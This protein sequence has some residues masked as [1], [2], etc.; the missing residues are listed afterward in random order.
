MEN[1]NSVDWSRYIVPL[2]VVLIG[3][4]IAY[5]IAKKL[6]LAKSDEQI[7]QEQQEQEREELESGSIEAICRNTP[8][9]KTEAEWKQIADVLENDLDFAGYITD[10][11]NDAVYQLA[12]A[13]NLCDVMKLVYYFGNRELRSPFLI[14]SGNYTLPQAVKER[15]EKDQIFMLN[16]NYR[17]KGIPYQF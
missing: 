14:K 6:G 15:L 16:D 7:E 12:R 13:K 3:G 11:G 8:T 10:Y 17:R 4:S 2:G 9:T 1:K 5:G